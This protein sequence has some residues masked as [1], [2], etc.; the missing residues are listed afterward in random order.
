M[1]VMIKRVSTIKGL[2]TY[3]LSGGYEVDVY[4]NGMFTVY[5]KTGNYAK[6]KTRPLVAKA[7]YE[8]ENRPK[9]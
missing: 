8:Y 3:I 9:G 7:I 5:T 2:T 4:S 6:S 1:N